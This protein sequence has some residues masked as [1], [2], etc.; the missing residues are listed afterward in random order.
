MTR[1]LVSRELFHYKCDWCGKEGDEDVEEGR[2][3]VTVNFG[4]GS[5]FD[6]DRRDFCSDKCCFEWTAAKGKKIKG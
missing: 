2:M 4:Y 6:G 3:P 1:E 5:H